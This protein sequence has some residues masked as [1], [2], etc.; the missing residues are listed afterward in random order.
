MSKIAL[1]IGIN[2]TS[3]SNELKGCQNDII[4]FTDILLYKYGYDKQN[5]VTLMDRT[6]YTL[7][8]KKNIE[9]ELN[10]L[11]TLSNQ[12]KSTEIFLYF[13]G[14]GTSIRDRNGD[15]KDRR[16]E[17][18]VPLDF[19]TN[20]IIVDDDLYIFL[21]K[22]YKKSKIICIFDACNS[23]SNTDLPISYLIKNNRI[24]REIYSNK[25]N[26]NKNIMII[27]GCADN[28][29]SYDANEPDGIPCGLLSYS[30][31]KTLE[32][33]EYTCSI[34][35]LLFGVTSEINKFNLKQV[36]VISVGKSS[37]VPENN[38]FSL[39]K[40]QDKQVNS[41]TSFFNLFSKS[42]LSILPKDAAR[43]ISKSMYN[44]LYDID[45]DELKTELSKELSKELENSLPLK[46]I[47]KDDIEQFS[48]KLSEEISTVQTTSDESKKSEKNTKK[49]IKKIVKK[50]IKYFKN[51]NH[52]QI[53]VTIFVIFIFVSKI[54]KK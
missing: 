24:T 5:I 26:L 6:G 19:L 42:V 46:I 34:K 3:T 11:I 41:D 4:K 28:N 23:A 48:K 20:G 21:S 7:P 54:T 13:S 43:Y 45:K 31:R 40:N 35:D 15:E 16:D 44:E 14:H 39:Y 47:L 18:I 37:I 52:L 53:I 36:P 12:N 22:L 29:V 50:T 49:N 30:I 27:S 9:D 38:L 51:K 25:Q 10:N 32:K 8:N 33:K 2:Y 1:M 17:C